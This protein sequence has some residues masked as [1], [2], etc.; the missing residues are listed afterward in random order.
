VILMAFPPLLT[1]LAVVRERERGSILQLALA[2]IRAWE[3]LGGKLLP[4]AAVAYVEMLLLLGA[5]H[6]WFGVP[7]RG[8]LP[9]LL[10]LAA[11]YVLCTVGI[12]LLVSVHTRSQV[13]AILLSIVLTLMPA[14]LFSG[15]L[16]PIVSMPP[17]FQAYT[18]LFPARHFMEIARGITLKGV[19]LERLWPSALLLVAYGGAVLTLAALS[20]RRTV[21]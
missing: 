2:P 13:V 7:V 11:L 16:F 3:F 18:H 8:S 15:F 9:L 6:L 12:G 10:G 19:G 4:Y 21:G 14:F 20:F 1:A 5:G 17:L